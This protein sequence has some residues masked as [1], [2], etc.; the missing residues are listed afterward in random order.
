MAKFFKTKPS[1]ATSLVQVIARMKMPRINDR[2]FSGKCP[3]KK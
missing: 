1:E 2:Y 3:M